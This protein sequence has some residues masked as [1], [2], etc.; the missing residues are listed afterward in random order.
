MHLHQVR[1]QPEPGFSG[2]GA[3]NYQYIFVSRRLGV[4]GATVHGQALGFGQNHIILEYR[5]DVGCNILMGS[6]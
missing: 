4:L 1:F 6:P 2:T 3:A 5:V